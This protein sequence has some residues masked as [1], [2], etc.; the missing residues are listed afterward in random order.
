LIRF[1]NSQPF[2]LWILLVG[3]A[4]WVL[5]VAYRGIFQRSEKRLTWVL[6]SLRAVGV[7][8]LILALAK[9]TLTKETR[10]IDPGRIAVI[11]DDSL[12]MSLADSSGNSRYSEARK[13]IKTLQR[14]ARSGNGPRVKL[15]LFDIQ[16]QMTTGDLP[17][18]PRIERTDL[19]H[20]VRNCCWAS[21]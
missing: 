11:V 21:F 3:A 7:I 1:E 2:W 10:K 18:E 8:A 13:A 12:S 16:G 6:L 20:A 15:D 4:A 14:M 17:A 19:V 9:P 5:Y